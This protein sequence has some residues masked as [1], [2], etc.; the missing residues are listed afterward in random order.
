MEIDSLVIGPGFAEVSALGPGPVGV[1]EVIALLKSAHP[2]S[3]AKIE[4]Q[5]L[6]RLV[7]FMTGNMQGVE[8][9]LSVESGLQSM[10]ATGDRNR[11]SSELS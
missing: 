1:A 2:V 11:T 10:T 5:R 9:K 3:N 4:R 6:K 8:A 7:E